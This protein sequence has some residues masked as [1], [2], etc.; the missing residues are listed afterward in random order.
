LIGVLASGESTDDAKRALASWGVSAPFLVD[1]A[2]TGQAEA[3]VRALPA[4]IVL[5][6]RG[7]A[8]WVAPAGASAD[9]VVAAAE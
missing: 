5:D 2:E 4:T 3:G 7:V 6:G 9:D 1:N 8:K